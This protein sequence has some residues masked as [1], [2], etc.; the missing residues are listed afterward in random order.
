LRLKIL[1][2]FGNFAM[3]AHSRQLKVKLLGSAS[4]IKAKQRVK[5]I[6]MSMRLLRKLEQGVW[7][8]IR[9]RIN[10]R[11]PLFRQN[12]A[13]AL[14]ARVF[15]ETGLRFAFG[16]RGFRLEDDLLSFYIE[17]ADGFELPAIMQW[18]K[19]VFARRYNVLTGRTGHIWGDRYW[20][21][22]LV[23]APPE[24]DAVA[25]TGMTAGAT[26][27]FGVRPRYGKIAAN[28]RFPPVFPLPTSPPPG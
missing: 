27:E 15:R 3:P 24:G 4:L 13:R 16:I 9:T 2:N 28:P 21:R 8:E 23:G 19:Q 10:N 18:M 14:F 7:Y 17:P 26:A 12:Q 6:N 11:E 5:P 1:Q 20:S 22:I 25:E